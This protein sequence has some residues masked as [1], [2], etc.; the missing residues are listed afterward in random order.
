MR[1]SEK[2]LVVRRDEWFGTVAH[3]KRTANQNPTTHHRGQPTYIGITAVLTRSK[4]DVF[5]TRSHGGPGIQIHIRTGAA[6]T[7]RS[8]DLSGYRAGSSTHPMLREALRQRPWWGRD[9]FVT[10]QAAAQLDWPTPAVVEVCHVRQPAAV[11]GGGATS[12]WPG[13]RVARE[14]PL[15]IALARSHGRWASKKVSSAAIQACQNAV[16]TSGSPLTPAAMS[17]AGPRRSASARSGCTHW[18]GR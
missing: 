4:G 9:R 11:A 15:A 2:G 18:D 5:P 10:E 12:R 17:R 8:H 13:T 7:H 3:R 6:Q 14:V 16:A 1:T